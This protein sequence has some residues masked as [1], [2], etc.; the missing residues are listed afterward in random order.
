MVQ[1]ILIKQI[2][3]V[4]KMGIIKKKKTG[5][6]DLDNDY[7]INRVN[8]KKEEEEHT[9]KFIELVYTLSGKGI[10]KIDGKEYRVTGGDMLIVNYHCRHSVTPI[11]NL[12]YVDIML[13]SQ[14]V[15]DTLKGTEDI[16]LLLNL[17][18]FSDFSNS[19]IKD[20]LLLR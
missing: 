11:E 8:L 18:D 15:N 16:F 17:R 5:E 1:I 9:H 10:H 19:V 2:E 20:N 7:F 3:T 13:K 6:F 4:E 14:Y 12:N